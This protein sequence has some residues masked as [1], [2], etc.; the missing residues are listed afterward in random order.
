MTEKQYKQLKKIYFEIKE[1][2]EKND[3]NYVYDPIV[4]LQR[5]E[6]YILYIILGKIF[7]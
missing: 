6:K 3:D 2:I 4:Y 1:E 5:D 7:E